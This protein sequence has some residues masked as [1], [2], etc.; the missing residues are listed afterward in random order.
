MEEINP[1]DL[2]RSNLSRVRIPE[3]T[4]RIYKQECCVSFDSPRS[5]GGLF[6]DMNTFLAFGK[7]YVVWN[8]EKTANPVYLHIKQTKK[9]VP[10]DRPSKKPT[11]LAIGVDGGFDNNEPE[12]E[13]TYNIVILPNYV[14]LPF[15]NVELPEK[16]RLAVDAILM[17]EG[18]ERKE[19][20]AAW[21][22]DKKLISAYAVDLRQIGNAVIPPS[23]WKCS[24]CDKTEN[25]WLNLTDGLILCGRRNWD[26]TGG[27]NHAIEHYKETGYPLAV[28]LGT[29]TAD[30]EAA[31]VFS[32]PEDD[33]VID[34]HLAEH[35]AY[36]GIDFSSL[37]KTEM[38]TAERELDQNTNFD[39][40]R[41]QESG[42]EVEPICG[43]GYTGLVNLG[44]SCYMAATMQVVFSTKSFCRRYYMDQ[45][46]KLAFET[47]PADPTVDLN[48]Q[49][50][51]LA[52]GMLSGKYSV[53]AS[54][55][56][57]GIPPRMFKAVIAASHPE[58]STMRQQDALEF[59]LH[60]LDQ[61]ERSNAVKPELDPTKSFKF[62]VEEQELE[63]FH[64]NKAEKVSEGKDVPSDEIVR[65]RVPLQAC[66][67]NF[68]AP[69]EIPEFYSTALNAKTTAIKTA[70][71]TSFPDYLVLHMRKFVMEAGWVPKKLD[72]YIDVPDIIDISHMRS[73]GLQPGEELLP[74]SGPGGE[75]ES[76]QPVANEEIVAQLVSMGFNQLH[77][78]KAA[79]NTFNA[80]VEEAMNWL[81]SHMDDADIDAP[82]S[83]GAQSA[84]VAVDQSKVDTLISFGFQEDVARMALKAS[85]G[86]IEKA[87][88]WIFNNPNASASSDMDTTTSSSSSVPA[89][90]DAGLPDG[91]GRYRLFGIV[92][93]MGTSTQCGHYV[94]HIL[95]DGRWVIF[96]DNKI[97]PVM[98][99]GF[100]FH[101]EVEEPPSKGVKSVLS[102]PEV[103]MM[104]G[105]DSEGMD[106]VVDSSC[107]K[108]KFGRRKFSRYVKAVL[109]ETSLVKKM[110]NKKSEHNGKAK[111]KKN[112]KLPKPNPRPMKLLYLKPRTLL[113]FTIFSPK[114]SSSSLRKPSVLSFFSS[115]ETQTKTQAFCYGPSLHKGKIPPETP[116]QTQ[117]Q[118][119]HQSEEEDNL[120]DE[121]KFTRIFHLAAL[122][123]PSN[124]CFAL[125]NR[126]RGHLLNWPRIKNIARVPG[127]EIE[128]EM[129]TLL[130]KRKEDEEDNAGTEGE[131]SDKGLEE[132]PQAIKAVLLEE[133]REDGSSTI[134]LVRC[135]LTLFYD[136]WPMNEVLEALLPDGMIIPSAFE[137]VGHIAHLNL[138]DEHLPYKNVIAKVVLDKNKPQ[139]K[140]VVN[141]IDAIHNEYRT[142]QLEVLAGNRSLVTTVVENGLR[143][144][145]DLATVYWNSRLGTERQRLLSGFNRNDVIC[146]VFSGVGPIAI[147]AAKIVKRVYAN[148]LNPFAVEY[149]ERNCVLN[150]LERRVK[151]FNMDGRRFINAMFSSEKARSITHVVMNLPNDAAEFLDAFR[152]VYRGQPKD[153]ELNYPMIHVYGFSKA[154]DP[155]FDFHERIRIALQEVA[156]N[157]DMHRVRLVA[158]GKW[159]LCA[160][161][162]LPESVAFAES[163][164]DM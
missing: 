60:F 106:D 162:I 116:F 105:S 99:N 138:K 29:I 141:K 41:I 16:V 115:I 144:H 58:F 148:D 88:D 47:A 80:G 87:T 129:M 70:G 85:G 22:A 79:I 151:V 61:V 101:H 133:T 110:R 111:S 118:S 20:V 5:E 83:H 117:N 26:G 132:L 19:Q 127:D 78:Q 10:E 69:E 119:T 145:V 32:Y 71:L 82:I 122:R 59:F 51:K 1:M 45:S 163:T 44:N 136:Y 96:N 120:I 164:L 109:F 27:N 77:C 64:K 153:E 97:S 55:K 7:D 42:Q 15:P 86:D 131:H 134:E 126:L 74:E 9:L 39:W 98:E 63:A 124:V 89:P 49:L 57:E 31:D 161:F 103:N 33:S 107:R 67:A 36:F 18:A 130:D 95:K 40:N 4:N 76:S 113:P 37:Q 125:E 43:P 34:P 157:V 81:L 147:S 94:A 68:A 65:P 152:G 146:D 72:V 48:M 123:I 100:D 93:H 140:T 25:L 142:M 108:H 24:K 139:I 35:L 8:Y 75:A 14:A 46:L 2:L 21:T 143:F 102:S 13:E 104:M 54:E 62:G 135:K 91:G 11:L 66:L 53:P 150:K 56:Q 84:E 73:K 28:K 159:M 149:L 6:V 158:P 90:V 12:Y 128:E 50:T 52:H 160:S 3:P 156:V 155:E 154:R 112:P 30:L 23:G 114:L 17:A 92:S 121:H 38:T 137:T